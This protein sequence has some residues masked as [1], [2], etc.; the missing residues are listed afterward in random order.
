MNESREICRSMCEG[1]RLGVHLQ[2]QVME[3]PINT[4]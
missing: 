2:R 1:H 3:D 4:R